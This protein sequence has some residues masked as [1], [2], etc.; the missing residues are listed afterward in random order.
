MAVLIE[1]FRHLIAANSP[2]IP[3]P[4]S[5]DPPNPPL[6]SPQW[7][8]PHR[9]EQRQAPIYR[10]GMAFAYVSHYGEP[11]TPHRHHEVPLVA[12]D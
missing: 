11:R 7:H 9:F 3:P 10:Q 5:P 2:P 4:P 6:Y 1:Q 12:L 8:V